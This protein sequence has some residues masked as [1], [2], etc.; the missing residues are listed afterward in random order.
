MNRVSVNKIIRF[1]NGRQTPCEKKN[2]K[3]V[4]RWIVSMISVGVSSLQNATDYEEGDGNPET[5]SKPEP[6]LILER[7]TLSI[8]EGLEFVDY[9]EPHEAVREGDKNGEGIRNSTTNAVARNR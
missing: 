8:N 6:P 4:R 5:E 1:L 2:I 9:F 3:M 7:T